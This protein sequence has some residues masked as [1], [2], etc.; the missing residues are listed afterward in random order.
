MGKS[1]FLIFCILFSM[2]ESVDAG[3]THQFCLPRE[4]KSLVEVYFSPPNNPSTPIIVAIQGSSC[5]SAFPWYT[6]LSRQIQSLGLGLVVIEKQGISKNDINLSEYHYTNCIEQR[7]EDYILCLKHLSNMYPEWNGKIIFWGESEGGMIAINLANQLPETAG[8][9]LFSTGGGI[10]PRE[11][12][13]WQLK[14]RLEKHGA[15][16][17]EVAQYMTLLNERMDVMVVDQNPNELFLGNSHK[18]WASLLNIEPI[19]S[20]M[21]KLHMPIYFVHGV[22]DVEIPVCSADLVADALKESDNFTYLRLE[23][24]GHHLDN[25]HVRLLACEWLNKTF[26][27]HLLHTDWQADISTYVL[28]RGGELSVGLE[29]SK[30]NQGNQQASVSVELSTNNQSGLNVTGSAQG[31]VSQDRNGEIKVESKIEVSGTLKF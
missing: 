26:S 18:W 19:L 23:A 8:L 13:K 10:S 20:K 25:S 16:E 9:L 21:R 30:D 29:A 17:D 4:N 14:H 5:E 11:E 28:S 2:F 12:V 24:Y 27:E 15:T 22:E 31:E 1:A 3:V 7:Q 6:H